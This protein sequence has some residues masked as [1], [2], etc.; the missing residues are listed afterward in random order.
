[1]KTSAISARRAVQSLGARGKTNRIPDGVRAVVLGYVR[2]ARSAG[3][4]WIE[5]AEAV[6]LSTSVLMRWDR[7]GRGNR[8]NN[9]KKTRLKRV[10]IKE[11]SQQSE[12]GRCVVLVTAAGERIEGLDIDDTVRILRGLR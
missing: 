10:V 8:K 12:R 11:S 2:E 1:M 3:S 5:V 7:E 6:G 9:N 4:S